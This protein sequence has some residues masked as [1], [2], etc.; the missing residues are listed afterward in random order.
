MRTPKFTCLSVLLCTWLAGTSVVGASDLLSAIERADARALRDVITQTDAAYTDPLLDARL[1]AGR[2]ALESGLLK[3]AYEQLTTLV[4]EE[5]LNENINFA[6]ALAAL[7][8]GEGGRARLAFERVVALNPNNDRARAELGRLHAQEGDL[9]LAREEFESVLSHKPPGHVRENIVSY[10][11]Q[12]DLADDRTHAEG[13]IELGVVYNDNFNLGP[14]GNLI[15]ITPITFATETFTSLAVDPDSEPVD[16]YGLWVL[17]YLSGLIDMGEPRAWSAYAEGLYYQD[18]LDEQGDQETRY[19]EAVG[20]F[21]YVGRDML[22]QL[23]LSVAHFEYG[24][25]PLVTIVRTRPVHRIALDVADDQHLI[26]SAEIEYRSYDEINERDGT[27]LG[28]SETLINYFES[29]RHYAAVEIGVSHDF[30]DEDIFE[31]TA[32]KLSLFGEV[33]WAW[34][35]V[36]HV[37]L[38]YE[39]ADFQ[40]REPLAPEDR[41]DSTFQA[42]ASLSKALSSSLSL[43]AQIQRTEQDST[44]DVYEYDQTIVRASTVYRF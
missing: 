13:R 42:M 36:S 26:S 15:D 14:N 3:K 25:E 27:Y 38:S 37:H 43:T 35:L 24:H 12:I 8:I 9:E 4:C 30:T 23:P 1:E 20:G 28:W 7:S 32:V 17:G 34:D 19:I 2:R 5:P 18:A 11:T 31:N 16:D 10:M 22:L 21:Q 6:Y 40:E 29:R 39:Y 44:F 41:E 33:T